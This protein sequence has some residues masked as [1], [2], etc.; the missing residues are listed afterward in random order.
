KAEMKASE[1]MKGDEFSVTVDLNA[2]SSG[3]KM[4]TCDLTDEYVHINADYRT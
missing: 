1:I 4:L 3:F 2:G